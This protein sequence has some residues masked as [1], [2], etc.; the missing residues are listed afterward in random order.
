MGEAEIEAAVERICWGE[1]GLLP[2]VAQDAH[3]G[4]VLMLAWMNQEALRRTLDSGDAWFWSRS[5]RE[6]WHKGATSGNFLHVV[7]VRYDCDADAVLLRVEPAGP[8]CH[9][10]RQSCFY[11]RLPGGDEAGAPP[12]TG[13]V[14]AH[15]EA[16]IEDRRAHPRSDSYT[17]QLFEGGLPLVA[18]KVGEEAVEVVVAAQGEE[19]AR[20]ASEAAD[21]VYHLLVLLAVRDLSWGDV[22]AELARRFGQAASLSLRGAPPLGDKV[23]PS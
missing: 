10:G 20:L 6:L 23:I 11:R 21:L 9:T 8:A 22:E 1:G 19:D 3:S 2:A 15:L 13:G 18:K 16:I 12:A 5:R 17:C 14:L 7:E 4:Q